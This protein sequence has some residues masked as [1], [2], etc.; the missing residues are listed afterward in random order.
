MVSVKNKHISGNT[1]GSQ[2]GIMP[3]IAS[4]AFLGEHGVMP[5]VTFTTTIRGLSTPEE[6][7]LQ[8][9]CL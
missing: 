1:E 7:G 5:F 6:K 8:Q 3:S 2:Q 9:T 4:N